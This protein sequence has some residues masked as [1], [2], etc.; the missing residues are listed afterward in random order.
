MIGINKI[1]DDE[2]S[3]VYDLENHNFNE[4]HEELI[5]I[6]RA[7]DTYLIFTSGSTGKPKGTEFF[8]LI[9]FLH[10]CK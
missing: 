10:E 7:N 8:F 4:N 5:N 3:I 1:I 9:N 2:S 6:S